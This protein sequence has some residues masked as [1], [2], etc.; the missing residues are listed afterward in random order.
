M[1]KLNYRTDDINKKLEQI[2][3]LVGSNND[4]SSIS[5]DDNIS[6]FID[7]CSENPERVGA[8][9]KTVGEGLL[10]FKTFDHPI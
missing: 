2:D 10:L 8:L 9:L 3:E 1:G 7:Y 5:G 4:L 6:K